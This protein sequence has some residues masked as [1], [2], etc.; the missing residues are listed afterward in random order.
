MLTLEN[1]QVRLE[2]GIGKLGLLNLSLET[3][4]NGFGN[5]RAI[6]LSGHGCG[7]AKR[8]IRSSGQGF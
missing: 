2:P 4:A 1:D 5:C 3:L 7:A 8:A 6:N